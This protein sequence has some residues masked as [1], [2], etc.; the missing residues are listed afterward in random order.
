MPRKSTIALFAF[1]AL[2][3]VR[4][5]AQTIVLTPST[6]TV[7]PAGGSLTFTATISYTTTPSVLGF[8]TTLPTG[9]SYLSTGGTNVPAVTPTAGTTGLL[10]WAY[11]TTPNSP[12]SFTFS[13]SYPAN[14]SGLQPLSTSAVTRDSTE[15]PPVTTSGPTV[16]LQGATT[17][18]TWNGDSETHTG[19]WTDASKWGPNGN[20]VPNNLGLTTY[21]AQLSQG[22]ATLSTGTTISL[23]DLFLSGGSVTGGGVITILGGNSAWTSGSLNGLGILNIASDATFSASTYNAHTFDQLNIINQGTFNWRDGGA[24]RSGNGGAFINTGTFNDTTSGIATD[25]LITNGFGGSFS[26]TNTGTYVKSTVGSTTR[27]EVPFTNAGNLRVDGGTLRFTSSFIQA[28]GSISVS[29]N[30]NAVFDNGLS[31]TNGTLTG[32]GKITGDVISGYNPHSNVTTTPGAKAIN[33]VETSVIAP[34]ATPGTLTIQGNLTL[35]ET[36]KL[37]FELGGTTQGVNYDFL[38]VSGNANLGGNLAISFANNFNQTVN[39]GNTFTLLSAAS[40]TGTFAGLPNGAMLVTT[41]NKATFVIT[42]SSTSVTLSNFVPVPEPSTWA[43]MI[44]GLGVI[45]VSVWRRRK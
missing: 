10:G 24:L 20:V 21:S 12:A 34:G 29:S 27:I 9:W 28:G 4:A 25:Y 14:L 2:L 41:D 30:A 36:S 32:A 42:Y 11:T 13:V 1:F 44:A 26:F 37:I 40:L 15:S 6:T 7:N 19:L 33:I 45:G 17:S 16:T 31:L 39:A 43:L 22:I 5:L 3:A 35:F 38:S 23:N 8:N 18:L